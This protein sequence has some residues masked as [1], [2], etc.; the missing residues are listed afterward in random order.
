VGIPVVVK[1]TAPEYTIQAH[2]QF[3]G[4][5]GEPIEDVK[6]QMVSTGIFDFFALAVGV[7]PDPGR[8]QIATTVHVAE[9]FGMDYETFTAYGAHGIAG[10][11]AWLEPAVDAE[12]GPVYFTASTIPD[13]SLAETTVDGG[14][15]WVNV[16]PGTYT[17]HASHP[18]HE[19][20]SFTAICEPGGF[21]NA[22]PPW[23]L[24]QLVP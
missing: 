1:V 8:C 16:P 2:R 15:V 20:Q 12:N 18:D 24:R 9:I 10:A 19:F 3:V 4:A 13:R 23:G 22:G 21:V 5:E 6:L 7:A 17:V 11:T 14:V